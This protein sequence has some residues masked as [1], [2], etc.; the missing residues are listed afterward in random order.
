MTPIARGNERRCPSPICIKVRPLSIKSS[1]QE[2]EPI[3][4]LDVWGMQAI[5]H[6]TAFSELLCSK[7]DSLFQC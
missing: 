3:F 5:D 4:Y 2:F 7:L 1:V 6:F